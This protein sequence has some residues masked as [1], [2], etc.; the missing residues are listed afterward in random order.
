LPGNLERP[1]VYTLFSFTL[2]RETEDPRKHFVLRGLVRLE[3]QRWSEQI[4]EINAEDALVFVHGFNNSFESALYRNAQI[5]YDLKFKGIPVLFSWSSRG[6]IADY[7]YDRESALL[8][9]EPFVEVLQLLA[10]CQNV[11]RVH[12]LAHSMGNFLVLDALH[13]HQVGSIPKL[14]ELM[15]AAPDVD[16]DQYKSIAA[17]VRSLTRGMTLYASAVDKALAASKILA[18]NIPRAGDVPA[19]GPIVLPDIDSIDAT[20]VGEE[21]FGL[22]HSTFAQSRSIL[23][24]VRLLLTGKRPP[25]ERLVEILGMPQGIDP[26][27]YW[28]YAPNR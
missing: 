5:I 2:Y 15:M 25:G 10:R 22:N 12:I 18:G 27:R 20:P 8:A 7:V 26:P 28:Q 23:N 24:D 6:A 3:K 11:K 16:R 9:R 4:G 1:A 14:C 13:H 21:I 19:D 17:K